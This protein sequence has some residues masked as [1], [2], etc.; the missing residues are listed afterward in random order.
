[1]QDMGMERD[2]MKVYQAYA[3]AENSAQRRKERETSL[4][5]AALQMQTATKTGGRKRKVSP[6]LGSEL[7]Y[8]DVVRAGK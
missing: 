5:E 8:P 3:E 1:M 2:H 7:H 6:T 4:A